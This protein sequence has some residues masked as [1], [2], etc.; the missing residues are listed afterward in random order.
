[1]L[2]GL[3]KDTYTPCVSLSILKEI[4][5]PVHQETHTRMFTAEILSFPFTS[6]REK[7]KSRKT[8]DVCKQ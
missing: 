8:P 5:A 6:K 1:M 2:S 3:V 4:C 7:Q